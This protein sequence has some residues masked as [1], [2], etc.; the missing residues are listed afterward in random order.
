MVFIIMFNVTLEVK[1][2][3]APDFRIV[4]SKSYNKLPEHIR[5]DIF[6]P[7]GEGRN[8]SVRAA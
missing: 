5:Y 7:I 8:N 1:P 4:R 3:L 6:P 2:E